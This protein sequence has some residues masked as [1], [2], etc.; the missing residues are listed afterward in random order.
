MKRLWPLARRYWFDVLLLAAVGLGLAGVVVGQ[1]NSRRAGGALLVR[2]SCDL[3]DPRPCFGPAAV[4]VGAPIAVGLAVVV[5]TFV[6]PRL[7]PYAFV[8]F[9][10][11]CAA[12][13][14]IGLLRDRR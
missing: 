14:L 1:G 3:G 8:P 7:V 6:D 9:L 10:A 11:G 4:P 2:H 13:F 12:V 5:T